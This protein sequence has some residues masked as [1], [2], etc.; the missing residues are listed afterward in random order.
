MTDEGVVGA[1]YVVVRFHEYYYGR[2]ICILSYGLKPF[3]D[4][5]GELVRDGL[6]DVVLVRY[7]LHCW[8]P[9]MIDIHKD[10]DLFAVIIS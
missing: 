2:Y 6:G 10:T 8:V 3:D 7:E 9:R 1:C 4:E 5:V